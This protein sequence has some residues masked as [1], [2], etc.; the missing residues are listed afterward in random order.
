LDL[1][2]TICDGAERG[3][4]VRFYAGDT[5]SNALRGKGCGDLANEPDKD[6]MSRCRY[7]GSYRGACQR[8]NIE[9]IRTRAPVNRIQRIMNGYVHHRVHPRF[10]EWVINGSNTD[11]LGGFTGVLIPIRNRIRSGNTRLFDTQ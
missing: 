8:W 3:S 5:R 6:I 10:V 2:R 4:I 9:C 7:R 1:A 11:G